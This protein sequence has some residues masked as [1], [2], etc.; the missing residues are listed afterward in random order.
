MNSYTASPHRNLLQ[1]PAP[2][3]S[4]DFQLQTCADL[5]SEKTAP[6]VMS[7]FYR[8]AGRTNSPTVC[9]GSRIGLSRFRAASNPCDMPSPFPGK[10]QETSSPQ[11]PSPPQSTLLGRSHCA[12]PGGTGDSNAR[13]ED[14]ADL[15]D[16]QSHLCTSKPG[17]IISPHMH[18]SSLQQ[19]STITSAN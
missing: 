2:E 15:N 18:R 5:R 17:Q 10:L 13:N 16:I 3:E 1:L 4:L 8:A 11:L 7:V 19:P 12:T 6:K 9:I 14:F